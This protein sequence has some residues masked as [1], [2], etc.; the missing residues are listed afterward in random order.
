[1]QN[2][3]YV[4]AYLR[5]K[6]SN[7]AK[8]GT[9]YYIGKGKGRRYKIADRNRK[10]GSVF[11]PPNQRDIIILESSLSEIG[12]FALERR[13]IKWWGR[14]DKGTGILEN[15][16]DGG[17][18][19]SGIIRSTEYRKQI[20]GA[21][22]HFFGKKH[23]S[24]SKKKM[25][26]AKKGKYIGENNPHWKGGPPVNRFSTKEEQHLAQSIF[27][28]ENNPMSSLAIREKHKVSLIKRPRKECPHCGKSLDLGGFTVHK[29]ALEKKGIII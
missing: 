2:I 3:Y 1:M 13:L 20:S 10:H 4:Y 12:A 6:D 11:M 24:E 7:V 25:S 27:M 16:S 26:A 17:E 5:S 21:G 22:N 8:A 29:R 28:K 19:P 23:S 14:K 9:P 15:R 18:G